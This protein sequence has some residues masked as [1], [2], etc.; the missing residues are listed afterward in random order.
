MTMTNS[1]TID[2]PTAP[3]SRG[4]ADAGGARLMGRIKA[5]YVE[6]PGLTLT[7]AQAARLWGL[8]MRESERLLGELVSSGFLR[9]DTH[10]AFR[11]TGC[12]RC[13]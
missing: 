11:R 2:A 5:E 6:M 7:L 1:A 9:R 13:A 12:P 3:A 4:P 10:G 8:P